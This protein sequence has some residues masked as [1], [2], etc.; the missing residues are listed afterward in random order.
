[1]NIGYENKYK[2]KVVQKVMKEKN[3]YMEVPVLCLSCIYFEDVKYDDY[4]KVIRDAGC[5]HRLMTNKFP[6]KTDQ[7]STFKKKDENEFIETIKNSI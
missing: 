2:V 1:M 4:H 7:C 6:I 3:K 5:Y